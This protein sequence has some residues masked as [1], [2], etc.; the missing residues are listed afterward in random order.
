MLLASLQNVSKQYGMQ[1]VLSDVTF[2]ISSGQK[3]GLIG[4]NGGG[5]TTLLRILLG[6]EESSGGNVVLPRGVRVG[7]VPQYVRFD[8]D[9][10]VWQYISADHRR[11]GTALREQE[12][13]LAVAGDGEMD[14]ALRAYQRARDEYD[15]V[16]GDR[17]EHQ[18]RAMLDALGLT[19]RDDQRI[20]HLS[21]GERNVLS[22]ARALLAEPDLLILDEPGNHLDFAGLA[23]LEEFLVAQACAVL[24]VSHN[25]YLLDRVVGGI[26]HLEAGRVRYYDGGYSSFRATRLRE[27]LAQQ[28]DYAANQ[29]RLSRLEALVKKFEQIARSTADPAWGARLRARRSQ[30][31]REKR[32]AVDRPIL[33]P[34][35]IRAD[36]STDASRANVALQVRN[37]SKAFGELALFEDAEM[38]IA[39]GQRVALVGANGS[40]KT[41]LLRDIVADG[42]WDNPSLRIGPSLRVGYCAQQ[43]EVLDPQRGIL[44]EL[45]AETPLSTNAAFSLLSRFL[46]TRDDLHKKVADLSG[47][48]RNRLQLARL[49]AAR[50]NFLILDEPTNHLDIHAREAV[51]EALEDFEGTILVV[52]HDRYFLEKVVDHVVELDDRRLVSYPGS[53]ADY[54]LTRRGAAPRAAG[55]ATQRR[56][57]RDKAAKSK[58]GTKALADLERQINDA[59]QRK[60]ELEREIADA[61]NRRDQREGRRAAK[62]LERLTAQLDELYRKWMAGGS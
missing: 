52:S 41:T 40:G 59:E 42:Q 8:E 25:R 4:A 35:A 5:K 27:L 46:F 32:Q 62:R 45:R 2:Q 38:D 18:A 56:R 1:T 31:A 54:W 53:F 22:L 47:G 20:A 48:E 50:P 14:R 24:I 13:R 26:L 3:L 29:K 33:G 37:Y 16:G 61:L 9:E 57:Q 23:W 39:C 49:M 60:A 55:R 28:A 21:G 7:Y 11:A 19:G 10:T 43:Q 6:Q 34:A 15:H 36:F 51:E 58:T 17:F 44:Q 12:E 30:L